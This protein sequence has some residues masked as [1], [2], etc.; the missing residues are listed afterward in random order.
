[1][2]TKMLIKTS[3]ILKVIVS[4]LLA[5]H[6][7]LLTFNL[8]SQGVAINTTGS[9]ADNSAMLDV[10]SDSSSSSTSQG[11]LMPRMRTANRPATPAIGLV[12]YN[13]DC[14]NFQY[15]DGN[16][17]INLNTNPNNSVSTPGLITGSSSVCA[18]QSI[19]SYNIS[20]VTGATSYIWT[21]PNGATI[22]SS[23]NP[24][25]NITVAFGSNAGNICVVASNECGISSASCVSITLNENTNVSNFSTPSATSVCVNSGSTVTINSTSLSTGTYTVT[26]NLSGTNTATGSTA[27]MSFTAGSP[28][29][30]T[31]I[32]SALAN[33]GATTVTITSIQNSYNCSSNVSSG[34][35]TSITV[36]PSPNVSNINTSATSPSILSA[37][38]VTVTSTSL[39]TGT[40]TVTYNLSGTNTATGSTASMSFT[41]GSPGTGTFITSVLANSGATTITITS[42]QNSSG[43]NSSLSSGN[44]AS[45]SPTNNFTY[46]KQPSAKDNWLAPQSPSD[47]NGTSTDLT[48]SD[49]TGYTYRPILYFNIS[50]FTG[51][52]SNISSAKISLYYSSNS[53]NNGTLLGKIVNVYKLTSDSWS[54]TTSSWSS[55]WITAGGDYVT[56]SPSGGSITM[57]AASN[58]GW[59]TID[60]TNI[61]KDAIDN[62]S[63]HV[64]V[65]VRFNTEGLA[66]VSSNGIIFCS[67]NYTANE[68]FRPKLVIEYA[69]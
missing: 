3:K 62:V 7:S 2:K 12:I 67:N 44:T 8:F 5:F 65:I 34:N 68:S 60:I 35:T 63:K 51:V 17:W 39:S 40:Y 26:Y 41:A 24:A 25:T 15:F 36:N 20:E 52:S 28:G 64:N 61:V 54:E 69:L 55:P 49:Y 47:N 48:L 29:A 11:M 45:I 43:C 42:I 21:I 53:W 33:S 14:S 56:S 32:T 58:Y 50:D 31:F 10:Q 57:P 9:D 46:T 37:S 22:A 38:T 19:V 59:V 27:S 18:N 6:F 66:Y 1:M 13:T 30:G 16:Q 4:A 23:S